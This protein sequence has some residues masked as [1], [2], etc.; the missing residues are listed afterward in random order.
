MKRSSTHRRK[1]A[2][3]AEKVK[4]HV[5]RDCWSRANQDRTVNEVE[6]AKMNSDAAKEFVF[7]IENIVKDVG[8]SQ[9]CCGGHEDGLVMIDSGASVNVGPK[10]FG[11]CV[12]EKSDGSVQLRGADGR[13]LQ[14]YGKRQIWLRFGNHLRRYDFHVVEVTKTILSVSHLCEKGIETHLV[15][16]PFLKYGERHEPLIKKSGVYFVKAQIVHEVKGAVEAVMQD[17]GSQTPCMQAEELQMSQHSPKSCVRTRDLQNT[18]KSCVR[19]EDSQESC[20]RAGDSQSA[21]K[22]FKK[23]MRTS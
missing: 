8:S 10:W 2:T 19:A 6:S 5:A 11:E 14:D 23:I 3:C 20:V 13:T 12:H 21:S 9:S 15:R 17:E 4:R 16:Q 18:Q 1:S 22:R 7:T